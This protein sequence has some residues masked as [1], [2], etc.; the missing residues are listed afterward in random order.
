MRNLTKKERIEAY[1]LTND[2]IGN[3]QYMGMCNGLAHYIKLKKRKTIL[4]SDAKN[5]FP[6]IAL[7]ENRETDGAFWLPI[8]DRFTRQIILD[9]CIE[10]A[11]DSKS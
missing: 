8:I 11:K 7:F 6:E 3:Y 2:G 9:F 4:G 10:M 5:H 1:R